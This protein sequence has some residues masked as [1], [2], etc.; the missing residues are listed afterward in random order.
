M[1]PGMAI[2]QYDH[3]PTLRH[4]ER[5]AL[6]TAL[7]AALVDL[8]DLS[9]TAKQLHWNV[10]GRSFRSLH[11]QLDELY[12]VAREQA[13]ELAERARALGWAP[14]GRR[15]TVAERSTLPSVPEGVLASEH[16]V[17]HVAE[18]LDA[19]VSSIRHA[20]GA[21]AEYDP[22][23]EDLLH[24]TAADLEKQAWMFSAM[25]QAEPRD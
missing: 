21:A 15:G 1:L 4:Q 3:H 23:T 6:G 5:D 11:L 17:A 7:Q 14:D 12:D 18:V 10:V 2:T 16:V 24:A 8:L 22:V 20:M 25:G 19:A 13:D 9:L